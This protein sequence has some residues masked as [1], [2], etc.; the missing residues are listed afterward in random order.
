MEQSYCFAAGGASR[1]KGGA[2]DRR[3]TGTNGGPGRSMVMNIKRR[4]TDHWADM[5]GV[6]GL[7]IILGV[8]VLI[9]F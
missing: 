6:L 4:Y 5:G 2:N 7:A 1:A 3:T 9:I 8:I